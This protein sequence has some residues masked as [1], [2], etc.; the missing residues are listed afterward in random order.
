[1]FVPSQGLAVETH[2]CL[3]NR[4]AEKPVLI[5]LSPQTWGSLHRLN[6][7]PSSSLPFAENI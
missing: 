7:F 3:Q 1:M 5:P 6:Q 2:G 4:P